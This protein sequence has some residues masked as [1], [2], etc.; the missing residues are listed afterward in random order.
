E[1][2]K[3]DLSGGWE[4]LKGHARFLGITGQFD[5]PRTEV[6]AAVYACRSAG[7]RPIIVTG[8]H[9]ATGL[10]VAKMLNI[11]EAGEIAIDGQELSL[12]S[13]EDLNA[14]LHQ[15]SVFARVHP[16]QKLRI[17]KAWQ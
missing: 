15:I 11:A 10:A 5:P 6:N 14:Q 1:N 16:A 8:D 3:V 12:I 17:V 2:P 7:V 13:D 9:K 4:S